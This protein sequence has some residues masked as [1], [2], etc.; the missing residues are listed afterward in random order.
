MILDPARLSPKQL[1][2]RSRKT[3]N[4]KER[5]PVRRITMKTLKGQDGAHVIKTLKSA[6]GGK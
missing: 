6:S 4:L 5:D 1:A 3:S 2:G